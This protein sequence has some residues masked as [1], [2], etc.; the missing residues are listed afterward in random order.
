MHS[1]MVP[2]QLNFSIIKNFL[3]PS[4]LP[5]PPGIYRPCRLLGPPSLS[6]FILMLFILMLF[7]RLIN[8]QI[9][10]LFIVQRSLS[11][12]KNCIKCTE[13]VHTHR[14]AQRTWNKNKKTEREANSKN[15]EKRVYGMDHH[16]R[17]TSLIEW[18][19]VW[20]FLRETLNTFFMK[21]ILYITLIFFHCG[22]LVHFGQ[23]F[24]Q[25]WTRISTHKTSFALLWLQLVWIESH[26]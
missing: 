22:A 23:S 4:R 8:V 21:L 19:S 24:G 5:A 6:L 1:T 20:W 13:N 16:K 15:I 11:S 12:R 10:L 25:V 26:S 17:F 7:I 3:F 18:S 14:E 9:S 2:I